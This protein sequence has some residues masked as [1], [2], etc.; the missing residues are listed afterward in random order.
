MSEKNLDELEVVLTGTEALFLID[1][2]H[3]LG[4]YMNLPPLGLENKMFKAIEKKCCSAF[5]LKEDNNLERKI[6]DAEDKLQHLKN[7]KEEK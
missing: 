5:K 3:G 4:I 2:Y 7:L 1:C 6:K